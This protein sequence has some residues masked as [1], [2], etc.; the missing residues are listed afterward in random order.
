M[1]LSLTAC[2]KASTE[3]TKKKKKTKKTTTEETTEISETPTED[4]TSDTEP[5]ETTTTAPANVF[6]VDDSLEMTGLNFPMQYWDYTPAFS[7]SDEDT[8]CLFLSVD[9]LYFED[10]SPYTALG[11][12][13][14]RDLKPLADATVKKFQDDSEAF[15]KEAK[16]GN[17]PD[18]KNYSFKTAIFR[19]DSQIFS[20]V[21]TDMAD[22]EEGKFLSFSYRTQDGSS[23]S[24]DDVVLDR[25]AL[26]SYF[27]TV[28]AQ[29]GADSDYLSWVSEME[30]QIV[31]GTIPF[32]L[33]YDGIIFLDTS[34][35]IINYYPYKLS[36]I[37]HE[38]IFNMEYFGKTPKYYTIYD[39]P[40]HN[41]AWDV[42]GDGQMDT[43][44][45]ESEYSTGTGKYGEDEVILKIDYNGYKIDS[46]SEGIDIF[47]Y[48]IMYSMIMKTDSGFYL[49]CR[50]NSIDSFEDTYVF[51]ID[52]DK[53]T[54]V[55]VFMDFMSSRGLINPEA[56]GMYDIMDTIGSQF[57]TSEFSVIGNNGMP[58]CKADLWWTDAEPMMT[59]IDIPCARV[60]ET[61]LTKVEDVTIPA[62][63]FVRP[64]L[65]DVQ[66]K[67]LI[68]AVISEDPSAEFMAEVDF[69]TDADYNMLINGKNVEDIFY[70]VMF[71]G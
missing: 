31:D 6:V 42:N 26:S 29:P 11:T 66:T 1:L 65:Y 33:T 37:G 58:N 28:F 41:I 63:S 27:E 36:V 2:S 46:R 56:F 70:G 4:T 22:M 39:D 62:G 67:R 24:F 12:A 40:N 69:S 51:K 18:G 54:Y 7:A 3:E 35:S 59:K 16:A 53:L 45:C 10:G 38:D 8:N 14:D 17:V 23:I 13:L 50:M 48:G 61:D 71:W 47:S 55:G 5:S 20:C 49:Y 21:V 68:V 9:Q 32:A 30:S 43:I 52:G 60:S 64:Y 44:V 57:F 15:L 25:S 19:S 34:Y